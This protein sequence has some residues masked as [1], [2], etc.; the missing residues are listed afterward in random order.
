MQSSRK[1]KLN[2]RNVASEMLRIA[3]IS[4]VGESTLLEE[5][6]LAAKKIV[7][8]LVT[9][10]TFYEQ[11]DTYTDEF[12]NENSNEDSTIDTEGSI[13]DTNDNPLLDMEDDVLSCEDETDVVNSEDFSEDE[14]FYPADE[15][16]GN[17][18]VTFEDKKKIVSYWMDCK[19]KSPTQAFPHRKLS[20]MQSRFRW[21]NSVSLLYRFKKEIENGE[22]KR[23]KM[24]TLKTLLYKEFLARR[25][26]GV[27]LRNFDLRA[28]ALKISKKLTVENFAAS[29][30]W[31]DRFKCKY[32]IVSRKVTKHVTRTNF[33]NE[34]NQRRV[35]E[36]FQKDVIKEVCQI[37]LQTRS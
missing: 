32:N 26:N 36:K 21:L 8:A 35:V 37:S 33:F 10:I 29:A 24:T 12:S 30:W 13:Q 15:K 11:S 9:G 20:S 34:E 28:M 27:L 2:P 17:E 31:I 25:R 14:D 5:E 18:K 1:F 19:T 4:T 7:Q 16:I 23:S 22:T 6:K 3:E